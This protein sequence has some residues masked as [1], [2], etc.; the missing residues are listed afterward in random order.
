MLRQELANKDLTIVQLRNKFQQLEKDNNQ[1]EKRWKEYD[2]EMRRDNLTF[3]G[4]S[5]AVADA[6]SDES[7]SYRLIKQVS[8]ICSN[9][10]Q[11]AIEPHDISSV[12]VLPFK[13]S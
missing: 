9:K 2:G 12:F 3:S 4:L 6:L 5:I 10:L 13:K 11:Y 1:L 8:E 7:S